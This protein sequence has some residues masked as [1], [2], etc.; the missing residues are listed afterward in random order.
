MTPH[1]VPAC[2]TPYALPIVRELPCRAARTRRSARAVSV[3]AVPV[4]CVRP[5]ADV[6]SMCV[7]VYARVLST[8]KNFRCRS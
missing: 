1:L 7:S 6:H 2:L 8:K 4:P 5:R 3:L